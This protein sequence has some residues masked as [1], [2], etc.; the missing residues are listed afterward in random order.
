MAITDTRARL[1]DVRAVVPEH[2]RTP[3]VPG[4]RPFRLGL[5]TFALAGAAY[6]LFQTLLTLKSIN[7]LR[8]TVGSRLGGLP[9]GLL[10]IPRHLTQ[11]GIDSAIQYL[12]FAGAGIVLAFLGRRILFAVPAVAFVAYGIVSFPQHLPQQ[13]GGEWNFDCWS[14]CGWISNVWMHAGVDLLLVL[15]PGAVVALTI[16]G[17]RWPDR[18]DAPTIAGIGIALVATVLAYRTA[19]IVNGSGALPETI[20]LAAFALLAGTPKRWFPWAHL[21]V[22]LVLSGCASL[23]LW[24]VMFP[25]A[26]MPLSYIAGSFVPFLAVVLFAGSWQPVAW[27]LRRGNARPVSML[28]GANLLNV[29]DAGL[30]LLA[31]GAGRAQEMNPFIRWMGMPAKLALVGVLTWILYRRQPSALVWP[32]AALGCVLCYHVSGLILNR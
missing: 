23:L 20:S 29:A 6:V 3:F 25:G 10:S 26:T 7:L 28:A 5:L 14:N 30:T 17:R 11:A 22:A 24:N 32:V 9:P 16:R 1:D 31:V 15:L 18:L 13:I 19:V 4:H 2:F 12:G 27:L 8:A 21:G